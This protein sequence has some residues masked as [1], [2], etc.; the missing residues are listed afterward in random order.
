MPDWLTS[1]LAI[2]AVGA[3]LAG[4]V[5]VVSKALERRSRSWTA[6]L[7]AKAA[8]LDAEAQKLLAEARVRE[9]QA[10]ITESDATAL[11][12]AFAAARK[13]LADARE[14]IRNVLQA[15]EEERLGRARAEETAMQ[16]HRDFHAFNAEARAG[17]LPKHT[18]PSFARFDHT[19]PFGVQR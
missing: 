19:Q 17:R 16:M 8:L 5:A 18:P 1:L 10:R 7:N 14:E 2:P 9:S 11:R 3:A 4:F 15:N 12:D 6:T 13:E